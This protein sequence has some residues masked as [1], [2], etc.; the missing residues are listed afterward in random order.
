MIIFRY[1]TAID[2]HWYYCTKDGTTLTATDSG[3]AVA[4][5]TV[6]LL[7]FVVDDLTPKVTFT[8]N[9]GNALNL[10]TNLPLTTQDFGVECYYETITASA[11]ILHFSNWYCEYDS[12]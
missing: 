5:N 7:K 4:A 3:L 9:G 10:T 12:T 6:Y 2:T 11:K 8:I 1:S